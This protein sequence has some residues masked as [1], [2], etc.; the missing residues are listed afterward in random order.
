MEKF[1]AMQKL[2]VIEAARQGIIKNVKVMTSGGKDSLNTMLWVRDNL[3]EYCNIDF[4]NVHSRIEYTTLKPYLKYLADKL[5]F[6][7]LIIREVDPK[8]YD[9]LHERTEEIG[10]PIRIRYC[11]P[12]IKMDSYIRDEDIRDYD[13]T[14]I[15]NRW[16]ESTNRGKYTT[17]YYNNFE[18][19]YHPILQYDIKTVYENIKKERIRLFW[20]YKYL[21]RLSCALCPLTVMRKKL[22]ITC[23]IAKQN[24]D[25]VDMEFWN[26]WLEQIFNV[27]IRDMNKHYGGLKDNMNSYCNGWLKYKHLDVSNVKLKEQV[28]PNY[29]FWFPKLGLEQV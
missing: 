26:K 10:V 5:K 17:L 6:G 29:G 22:S 25:Q 7:K 4:I 15:G 16:N 8:V 28:I 23:I 9:L 27:C 3:A 18:N 2:G 21:P 12:I 19:I 11:M 14:I 24:Q 13:L 1:R 20:T